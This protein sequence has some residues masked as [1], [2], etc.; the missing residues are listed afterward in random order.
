MRLLGLHSYPIYL[1]Y[2]ST[3]FKIYYSR[4][5][6]MHSIGSVSLENINIERFNILGKTQ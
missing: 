2:I 3:I 5:L 4:H 1:Y 6:P